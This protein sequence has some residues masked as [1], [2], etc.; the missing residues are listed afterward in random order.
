MQTAHSTP[1]TD[2][3]TDTH[4]TLDM[5][6]KTQGSLT[7]SSMMMLSRPAVLSLLIHLVMAT[8]TE[9]VSVLAVSL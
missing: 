5:S 8:S 7:S 3:Q 4:R 2:G 6:P 1:H 9:V